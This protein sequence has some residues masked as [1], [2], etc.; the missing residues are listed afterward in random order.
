[1]QRDNNLVLFYSPSWNTQ[2]HSDSNENSAFFINQY[3]NLYLQAHTGKIL[4]S[5]ITN[6]KQQKKL[7]FKIKIT[8]NFK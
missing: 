3:G 4:W 2:T 7:K 8:L 5:H 6:G 1:M